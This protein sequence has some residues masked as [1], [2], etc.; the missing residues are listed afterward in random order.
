MIND[1]RPTCL[2]SSSYLAC[3]SVLNSTTIDELMNVLVLLLN[4]YLPYPAFLLPNFF[5][6]ISL[7]C[8]A[9]LSTAR[10]PGFLITF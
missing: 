2:E 4:E 6:V 9:R 3:L 1:R 10:G 5:P 8:V 7:I